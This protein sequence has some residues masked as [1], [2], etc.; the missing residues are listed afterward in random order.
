M[1]VRPL[2]AVYLV[3]RAEPRRYPHASHRTAVPAKGL[4]ICLL[5]IYT[6]QVGVDPELLNGARHAQARLVDAERAMDIAR[7]DFRHAVRRL[8][9]AG[10]SLREIADTL[11][12]SHQRVHQIVEEAGGARPSWRGYTR[13]G[14]AQHGG[15]SPPECS[16]CG[17][18]VPQVSKLVAG[19]GVYIC[20]QC[21]V[22]A[23]RVIATGEVTATPLSAI[24]PADDTASATCSFCGKRR[25]QVSGLAVAAGGSICTECLSLCHE[26]NAEAD[27][28]H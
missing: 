19:S 8:H 2:K 7:A 16:F 25:R 27:G 22:A 3:R 23:D 1:E 17:K 28:L 12:L 14:A 4:P 10:G 24:S 5:S 15:T 20:D 18:Y 11:G 13:R 9:L 26:I 21:V 6:R